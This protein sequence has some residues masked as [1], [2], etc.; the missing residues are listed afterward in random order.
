MKQHIEW[1]FIFRSLLAIAGVFL[2]TATLSAQDIIIKKNAEEIK[3]K[4]LEISENSVTY[5]KFSNP[6]GPTYTLPKSEIF[7]IKYE[8]GEKETFK[9]API[10][11]DVQNQAVRVTTEEKRR[12]ER[13]SQQLLLKEKKE[14]EYR[15]RMGKHNIKV[16]FNGGM[17]GTPIKLS[18]NKDE[19]DF[20]GLFGGGID[21]N[22]M[23]NLSII[24]YTGDIGIGLGLTRM[25]SGGLKETFGVIDWLA[26]NY[27]TIPL[28][29]TYR[30]KGGYIGVGLNNAIAI[31]CKGKLEGETIIS[32]LDEASAIHKYRF[33]MSFKGGFTVRKFD[34]GLYYTY[35]M[36]DMFSFENLR[37]ISVSTPSHLFGINLAYR[38]KLK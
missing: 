9:N 21:L 11:N 22:V 34:I 3:A 20:D 26:V 4:I 19:Y 38:I 30:T 14:L 28:E 1:N 8:N 18:D 16:T 12:R 37:P 29:M 17:A 31:G 32:S 6:D 23:Y 25:G 7:M 33:G 5:K 24:D 27:L 13:Q 10:S 35:W 2:M 36:T 15:K